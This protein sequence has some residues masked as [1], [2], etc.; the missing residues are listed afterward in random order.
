MRRRYL[1]NARRLDDDEKDGRE[2]WERD[3][4]ALDIFDRLVVHEPESRLRPTGLF[5]AS[6]NPIFVSE[7]MEPIGYVPKK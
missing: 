6:G 2:W 5:D 1:T 4:N 7:E 3:A